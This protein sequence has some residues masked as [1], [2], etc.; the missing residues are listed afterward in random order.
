MRLRCA[1]PVCRPLC[2]EGAERVAE[3]TVS[4]CTC[5]Q[6]GSHL[7]SSLAPDAE[8]LL[9]HVVRDADDLRATPGSRAGSGSG[10]R[11]ALATDRRSRPRAAA[12]SPGRRARRRCR[13]TRAGAGRCR[14]NSPPLR[15]SSAWGSRK[16]AIA[17]G[18]ELFLLLVGIADLELAVGVDRDRGDRR[19]P[20][21]RRPTPRA[22]S[23]PRPTRRR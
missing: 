20:C 13:G 5:R 19:R 8:Q 1:E 21:G 16:S 2:R 18:A 23:T 22:A 11:T 7:R 12:T 9:D 17:I 6:P 4:N 3:R 14:A 15:C 10:R